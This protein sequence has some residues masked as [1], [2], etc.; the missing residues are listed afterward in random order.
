[1]C[2]HKRSRS[3]QGQGPHWRPDTADGVLAAIL[4]IYSCAC[5]VTLQRVTRWRTKLFQIRHI[6]HHGYLQRELL[7]PGAT[8]RSKAR[9]DG[10]SDC[11]VFLLCL[12][13]NWHEF[14]SCSYDSI[15]LG[16]GLFDFSTYVGPPF[17]EYGW[18]VLCSSGDRH[19]MFLHRRRE[20]KAPKPS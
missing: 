1:M 10:F 17:R 5:S 7:L 19:G 12:A 13:R 6:Q 2:V 15:T 4:C 20:R 11:G 3:F 9:S 14:K 16:K 8:R 18:V